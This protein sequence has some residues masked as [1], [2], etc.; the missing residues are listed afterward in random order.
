MSRIN[1]IPMPR[2]APY[3]VTASRMYSEQVGWN[4]QALGSRGEIQ[5][6]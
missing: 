1:P 6:L 4:R 3:F 5:R 2:V